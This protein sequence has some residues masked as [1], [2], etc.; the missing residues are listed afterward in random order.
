MKGNIDSSAGIDISG[1]SF[2]D[3]RVMTN[4]FSGKSIG[5]RRNKK[6][7]PRL[8]VLTKIGDIEV[9]VWCG[10]AEELIIRAGEEELLENLI[11][12][13]KNLPWTHRDSKKEQRV[14]ALQL[15]TSRIFD[16]PAWVSF[17]PFNEKW[18]PEAL[19]GID[20]I[21]I[22][23]SCC[24][25]PGKVTKQQLEH[26]TDKIFCP[27]CGILTKYQFTNTALEENK[28]DAVVQITLDF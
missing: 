20:I 2:S 11:L 27:H 5:E 6:F 23:Q 9:D 24:Q 26:Y 22:T 1:L 17:I 25:M 3:I 16:N 8:G 12:Y 4:T 13:V 14:R 28:P 19:I 18:R 21:E 10:L 7:I 15:H